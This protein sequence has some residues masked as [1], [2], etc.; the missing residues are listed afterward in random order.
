MKT[1]E[2]YQHLLQTNPILTCFH[3]KYFLGKKKIYPPRLQQ[4]KT[5]DLNKP[6][7]IKLLDESVLKKKRPHC[8]LAPSCLRIIYVN[9]WI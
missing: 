9:V 2:K 4:I 8:G 1:V 5:L 7:L 6:P 3:P